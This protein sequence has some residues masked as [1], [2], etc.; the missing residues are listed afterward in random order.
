MTEPG[1]ILSPPLM[2]VKIPKKERARS[3]AFT[4]IS[5]GENVEIYDHEMK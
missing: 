3:H 4:A 1:H 5:G 2:A